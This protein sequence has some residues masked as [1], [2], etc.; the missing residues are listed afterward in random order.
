MLSSLPSTQP[1]PL[2]SPY[3]IVVCTRVLSLS[4]FAVI[5]ATIVV[6][7]AI[8]LV[9]VALVIALVVNLVTFAVALI[10]IAATFAVAVAIPIPVPVLVAAA[11]AVAI[12]ITITVAFIITTFAISVALVDCCIIR[13]ASAHFASPDALVCVGKGLSRRG[14]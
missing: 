2:P 12:T 4:P 11:V 13:G 5:P 7:F 8:I 14:I 3:L 9:A 1:L 6:L 10:A